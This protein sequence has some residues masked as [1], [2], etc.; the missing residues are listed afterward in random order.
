MITHKNCIGLFIDKTPGFEPV[1]QAHLEFWGNDIP[2]LSNDISKLSSYL[3]KNLH[4]ISKDQRKE[5]FLLVESC[6]E[7]GDEMVKNAVATCLLEN[8][9]N[10]VSS[11]RVEAHLFVDLLGEKSRNFCKAWD[12]FTGVHTQGL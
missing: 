11:E 4:L 12:D 2:G 6:L 7:K 10:A 8:M 9:L 1:W 3:I 5:I